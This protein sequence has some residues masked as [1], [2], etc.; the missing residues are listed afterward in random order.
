METK[1]CNKCGEVKSLDEFYKNK[2]IK[3]GY[4]G[5]CRECSKIYR[6]K[7]RQS[8]KYK[9]YQKKYEISRKKE[10]N[11]YFINYKNNGKIKEN[12]DRYYLKNK[13]KIKE[14]NS[15]YYIENKEKLKKYRKNYFNDGRFDI[16]KTKH[17][18]KKEIGCVPPK[19]LIEVKLLILKT[20]KLCKTSNNLE[21]V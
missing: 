3:D 12:Y 6:K 2:S 21:P 11:E 13:D 15:K 16:S 7:Y 17:L 10:R 19:E 14:R 9:E 5:S 4:N 20:K 8:E 1:T 18:L